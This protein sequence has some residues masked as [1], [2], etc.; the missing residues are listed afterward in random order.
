M[1]GLR[2]PSSG[3]R[4]RAEPNLGSL[5]PPASARSN[6][7]PTF[8]TC[9]GIV[10][11]L[12]FDGSSFG[13]TSSHSIGADTGAPVTPRSEYGAMIVLPYAFCRQSR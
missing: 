9:A 13:V 1:G 6:R 2:E 12:N 4:R 3:P 10:R 7:S 11:R 5:T 8:F